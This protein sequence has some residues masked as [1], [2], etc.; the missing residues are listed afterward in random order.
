VNG[1]LFEYLPDGASPTYRAL[2]EA[3]AGRNAET[4][5][6]CDEHWRRF[7]H[8]ADRNFADR[9]PFE[10]QQRWFEMYLG[11]SLLDMG[12]EVSAP[13]PGPDL[14]VRHNGTRIWFEAIAPTAGDPAHPDAV[15]EPHVAPP[16][17]PPV[18]QWVPRDQVALRIAQAIRRKIDAF[19][20]YRLNRR[21]EPNDACI[22]AV[23]VRSIPHAWMDLID[24]FLKTLYGIGDHYVVFHRDARDDGPADWGRHAIEELV[25]QGG[26]AE[27]AIPLVR[28]ENAGISAV[29]GSR[30]DAANLPNRLGDDLL[31]CPHVAPAIPI[32]AT[33]IPRGQ[34][35]EIQPD[36][37]GYQARLLG[38]D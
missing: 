4:R 13:K 30:V 21:I 34:Y 14:L 16:G 20:R 26:A 27:D 37:D 9:F 19:D 31:L 18:A 24:Y 12:L 29:L 17:A 22:I 6:L 10:F 2:F 32:P 35:F 23:N 28:P 15:P 36:G 5:E 38:H 1:S 7:L 3:R 8:L 25:R 33:S 11:V